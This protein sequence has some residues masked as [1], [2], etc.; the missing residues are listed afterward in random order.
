MVIGKPGDNRGYRYKDR[1]LAA[2]P[3]KVGQV[4]A[5]KISATAKGAGLLH[6]LAA[7]PN[8]VDVV[9]TL[10]GATYCMTFGGTTQTFEAGQRFRARDALVAGICPP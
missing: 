4:R 5:A 6:E 1:L 8:P 10:G 7:N 2:G 3:V 9:L